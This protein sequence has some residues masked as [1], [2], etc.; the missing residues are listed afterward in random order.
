MEH[1]ESYIDS[2][3]TTS[4]SLPSN[5]HALLQL[6]SDYDKEGA[7]WLYFDML[8]NLWVNSKNAIA[9]GVMSKKDWEMIERKYWIHA[10]KIYDKE[11]L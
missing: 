7:W 6:L 4:E 11:T 8:D 2:S 9:A 3:I 5:I 10:D 1:K